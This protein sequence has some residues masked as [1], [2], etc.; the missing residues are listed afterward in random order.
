MADDANTTLG[1]NLV[2]ID[3]GRY[4]N[5]VLIETATGKRHRFR[6][7]NTA[8]DFARLLKFLGALPG[9]CRIGLEPTGDYHR[10]IAHRLLANGHDVVSINSVALARYG[11]AMFH[12][13]DKNDPKDASVILEML[14]RG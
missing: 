10:P 4:S 2:A 12:S 14:R 8:A 6:M 1:L 11:D 3:I 13:W 5:A 7:A 9:K